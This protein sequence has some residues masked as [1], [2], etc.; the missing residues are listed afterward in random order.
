MLNSGFNILDGLRCLADQL[1]ERDLKEALE[2]VATRVSAGHRLSAAMAAHQPHFEAIECALVKVGEETGGLHR[3]L[4]RLAD[5]S[6]Q[7]RENHQRLISALTYPAWVVAISTALLIFAPLFVLKDMLEL[8]RELSADLP[9]ITKLY[10]A[11]SAMLVHPLFYLAL[12]L[13]GVAVFFGLRH[14]ANSRALRIKVE[15]VLLETPGLGPFL[16]SSLS[17]EFSLT[18]GTCYESGIVVLDALRLSGLASRSTWLEEQTRGAIAA[19]KDG[20]SL[21]EALAELELFEP[22]SLSMV[23]VG[24]EAGQVEDSLRTI[25]EMN[26][27]RCRHTLEL[28]QAMLEPLL[29]LG[30]GLLVGFMAIATLTPMLKVAQSL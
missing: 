4:H 1:E 16:R 26:Q 3:V 12:V 9:L 6:E 19:L 5:M 30:V 28:A 21:C 8:I 22:A 27:Q 15:S 24:E 11:F 17:L 14:L 10:L 13:L 29:L 2:G 23:A 20:S 25:A 7:R 18:L